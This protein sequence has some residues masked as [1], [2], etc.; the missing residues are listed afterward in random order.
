MGQQV[1][2]QEAGLHQAGLLGHEAGATPARL[3]VAQGPRAAAA[4]GV[5]GDVT[6]AAPVQG[7]GPLQG[8]R[9][10]VHAGDQIHR[11]RGGPWGVQ[12][13]RRAWWVFWAGLAPPTRS[14]KSCSPLRSLGM[15]AHPLDPLEAPRGQSW[16]LCPQSKERSV[17]VWARKPPSPCRTTGILGSASQKVCFTNFSSR[18]GERLHTAVPPGEMLQ[19]LA[20]HT[21]LLKPRLDSM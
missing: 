10:P 2:H 18:V 12:R 4:H 1:G 11:C 17:R 7:R 20:F 6:A 15:R 8:H 21:P 3:A 19:A 13:D 16:C 9:R 5:V 14:G